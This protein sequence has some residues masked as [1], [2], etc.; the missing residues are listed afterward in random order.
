MENEEIVQF[1]KAKG[2]TIKDFEDEMETPL[3]PVLFNQY[4]LCKDHSLIL[5]FAREGLPQVLS[6]ELL[7]LMLQLFKLSD[8]AGLRVGYN[9]MGADCII[10]NLH[11]H[12]FTT[13][14]MYGGANPKMAIESADKK[15]FYKS[16]LKHKDTD[17]INMYNC[18]IRFG[19]VTNY[20]LR[21]LLISPE[22]QSE[23]TSLEDA[24]EALAHTCGVV[25][26]LM[27]DMNLPHNILVTDEGMTVY[28]IPRKFDMVIENVPFYTSFE[29]L[30]GFVKYKNKQA[31]DGATEASIEQ[32]MREQVS[33]DE[34][35]FAGFQK[36]IVDKFSQEYEGQIVGDLEATFAKLKI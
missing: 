14:N 33:L 24:Q 3:H 12:V 7:G 9:S 32:L 27:I 25:I 16:N 20:P 29:S 26:N 1:D 34:S 11:F 13:D 6:D 15:L 19:E 35:E 22:I 30:C 5:L 23:E 18:G 8:N 36:R 2:Q 31:F 21:A 4:P 28:V 10:N 17:E